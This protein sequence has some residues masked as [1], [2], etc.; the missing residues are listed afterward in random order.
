MT[1]PVFVDTN[2]LVYRADGSE[3]GKQACADAWYTF[4]WRSRTG[5]LSFQVLQELY[6]VL[7][8]KLTP[9]YNESEARE[10][11]RELTVWKPVPVDLS[12]IESGWWLQERYRLSWWDALIVAAASKCECSVLLT[13]DLQHGQV[14]ETVRV[15]D[16]FAESARTPVEVLESVE[17]MPPPMV[18]GVADDS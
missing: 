5:R 14:F 1:G 15:I 16:P 8:R 9:G 4:L 17:A 13:E 18:P 6:S 11:V 3:P 12:V 2:V 7:T 10:I